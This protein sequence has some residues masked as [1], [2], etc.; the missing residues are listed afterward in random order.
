MPQHALLHIS[1]SAFDNRCL[2]L[3]AFAAPPV[4]TWS[5]NDMWSYILYVVLGHTSLLPPTFCLK[6]GS[7]VQGI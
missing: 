1:L 3:I 2:L 6:V 7:F 4:I 5:R